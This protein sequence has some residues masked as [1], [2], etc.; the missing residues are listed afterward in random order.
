MQRKGEQL[1]AT[2][3]PVAIFFVTARSTLNGQKT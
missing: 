1:A 2:W 3:E